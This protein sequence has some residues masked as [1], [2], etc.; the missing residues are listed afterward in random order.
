MPS[1]QDW[2]SRLEQLHPSEIELGLER[3]ASVADALGIQKPAPTVITVAGTNGKGSCV[4]TM[5]A[6]LC[7]GGAP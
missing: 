2:L 7:K 6:L 4:A 3:V 5:E 1:L